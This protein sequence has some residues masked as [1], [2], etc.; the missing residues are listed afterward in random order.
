MIGLPQKGGCLLSEGIITQLIF[1]ERR[2]SLTYYPG[3]ML[4]LMLIGTW[5]TVVTGIITVGWLLDAGMDAN[6]EVKRRLAELLR[7]GLVVD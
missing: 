3:I 1:V 4:L 6:S 7:R 2:W 5:A